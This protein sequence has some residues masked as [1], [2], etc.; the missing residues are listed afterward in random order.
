M[1]RLS[2]EQLLAEVA[3]RRARV[4]LTPTERKALNEERRRL[5]RL[6]DDRRR[7]LD[8]PKCLD[9]GRRP[10]PA[11]SEPEHVPFR[12]PTC[13]RAPSP[14]RLEIHERLRELRQETDGGE[15]TTSGIAERLH[16]MAGEKAA[17]H[18][19]TDAYAKNL[20]VAAETPWTPTAKP[21]RAF[22]AGLEAERAHRDAF[23]PNLR[24]LHRA[25]HL[26]PWFTWIPPED[27]DQFGGG[28]WEW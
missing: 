22:D 7:N 24:L 15:G 1:P 9:C 3:E 28:W 12:C 6:E 11:G 5:K 18:A 20:A 27:G 2:D 13:L 19:R 17:K 8:R 10:A 26:D 21:V 25:L 14:A 23:R 16:R 4:G